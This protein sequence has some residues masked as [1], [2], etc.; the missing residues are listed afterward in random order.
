MAQ[1]KRM[2]AVLEKVDREKEYPIE[3][4]LKILKE[5]KKTKFDE[6]V[7]IVVRLGIDPKKSDQAIRGS[8]TMPSGLG[9]KIRVLVFAKGDKAEEAKAAN[10]DYVGAEDLAEKITGGWLEFDVAVATPDMMKVIGKLGKIL[11]TRGL[12]PNPK[13]GTVTLDV[14]KAVKEIK[15]GKADFRLDKA[16]NIHA[17]VGKS[18]FEIPALVENIR[19][20]VNALNKARPASAKGVYLR[21]ISVSTTM[22]PGI[23]LNRAFIEAAA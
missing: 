9:K 6:S 12:M 7:D 1:S 11:G 13:T 16:A 5:N 20:F 2:K 19:A 21:K 14:G 3:E 22:G 23:K 4:A 18:S 15:S 17:C 10:A 8:V